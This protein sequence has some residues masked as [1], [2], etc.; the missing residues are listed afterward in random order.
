MIMQL[1]ISGWI[2]GGIVAAVLILGG[3]IASVI[4]VY[5][6][7]LRVYEDQVVRTSKEKFGSAC[8]FTEV[9]EQVRMWD[10][11]IAFAKTIEDKRQLVDI[12]NDG[13][14]LHG[15]YYDLGYDRCIIV[16]PGRSEGLMY[17]YYFDIPYYNIGMNILA[18]D[19]RA[20]GESEGK[21][22]SL[23]HYE[24]K[25][26][27][28]W[29]AWLEDN[30]GI[31]KVFLHCVCVGTTT[32]LLAAINGTKKDNIKAIITEGCFVSFKETFREHVKYEKKPVY[33]ILPLCLHHIQKNTGAD[34]KNEAPIKLVRQIGDLPI[35]FL[36]SRE[37]C[38]SLPKKSRKLFD[39][40][41]S[42][43]K[44]IVW[45]DKGFHSRLRIVNEEGFDAAIKEFVSK[46][47]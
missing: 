17:G 22:H 36:Y 39:T 10:T 2:I 38:F 11:G 46:C 30:H 42:K 26:L 43:N 24:H 45:F 3:L 20:H 4:Y 28:K 44:Q 37:D 27:D 1:A 15:E 7:S 41:V 35:L 19:P 21:Y 47:G 6:I 40:C 32:G 29:L 33:P 13:L 14:K 18:I 8:T 16:I 34:I 12:E 5:P 23:G 31:R 9:E 25:D